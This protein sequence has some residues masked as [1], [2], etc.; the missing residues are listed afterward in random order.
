MCVTREFAA[1][2]GTTAPPAF[3]SGLVFRKEHTDFMRRCVRCR[4][5]SVPWKQQI[6]VTHITADT[7]ICYAGIPLAYIFKIPEGDTDC[8]NYFYGYTGFCGGNF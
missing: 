8:E 4:S 7:P 2:R 6:P 5:G 1:A 3:K